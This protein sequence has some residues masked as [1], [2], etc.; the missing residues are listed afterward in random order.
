MITRLALGALSSRSHQD[1]VPFALVRVGTVVAR[2]NGGR[3]EYR[4]Y[5]RAAIA[6]LLGHVFRDKRD[7][8][9]EGLRRGAQFTLELL[10]ERPFVRRRGGANC[11][12]GDQ[13]LGSGRRGARIAFEFDEQGAA[14][15]PIATTSTRAPTPQGSSQRRAV[16][17]GEGA[18]KGG[19]GCERDLSGSESHVHFA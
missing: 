18:S 3:S 11:G 13:A 6:A 16:D 2:R 10:A 4:Q 19:R 17:Q 12:L 7:C 15:R 8:E 14:A 9:N 1:A 5:A